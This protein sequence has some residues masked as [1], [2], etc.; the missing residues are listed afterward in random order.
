MSSDWGESRCWW[1]LRAEEGGQSAG[2]MGVGKSLA[3]EKGQAEN[4]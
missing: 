3:I 1:P 4:C 2:R